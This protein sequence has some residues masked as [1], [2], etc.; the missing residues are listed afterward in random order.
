MPPVT[1]RA[2]DGRKFSTSPWLDVHTAGDVKAERHG[3]VGEWMEKNRRWQSFWY[4]SQRWLSLRFELFDW[5]S[6]LEVVY[7]GTL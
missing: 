7:V 4:L 5:C 2:E 3:L 6:L 1:G